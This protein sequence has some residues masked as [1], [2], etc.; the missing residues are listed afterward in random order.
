M[1]TSKLFVLGLLA[2]T[3][4]SCASPEERAARK[5]NPVDTNKT[6]PGSTMAAETLDSNQKDN[7]TTS[8]TG[9]SAAVPEGVPT[10]ESPAA[11]TGAAATPAAP[12]PAPAPA[13]AE[14]VAK[15]E[16]PKAGPGEALIKKSDCLACHNA[17][18][19]IVGPAY[20]D[21]AAKYPATAENIDKLADKIIAGGSGV[22]GEVPMSAHS[23]ISKGDAKEM[24]KYI[25][26]IKK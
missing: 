25:L 22:W 8:P 13:A 1:K 10:T 15:A 26:S 2:F 19:K 9:G 4:S 16:A 18:V 17:K 11:A 6:E 7:T 20:A 14:K 5:N 24:V 12:A 23:A 3:F 21:V